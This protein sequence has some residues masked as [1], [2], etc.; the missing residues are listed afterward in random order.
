M[1]VAEVVGVK[2]VLKEGRNDLRI[3]FHSPVRRGMEKLKQL[4]YIIPAVNEQAP[5]GERSN[6]FTRKAPFHYGW[7]WGPR[8]VTSGVWRPVILRAVDAAVLEDV[9][10]HTRSAGEEVAELEGHAEVQVLE[11]GAYTLSLAYGEGQQVLKQELQLE[12]GVQQLPLNFDLQQPRLWWSKGLGEAYLYDFVFELHKE[13]KLVDRHH[14]PFGVRTLRLVQEPDSVGHS[15]YFELNGVPVFMKGANVIP[16][17]TLIPSVSKAD[18]ERLIDNAVAAN[19]NMV[20]VWGGAIY[21]EDYF[22]ELCDQKDILVWQD[23]MF[24]CRSEERRVG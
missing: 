20:R 12:A 2:Q 16:S 23:F 1:F 9:Y 11:A 8:L 4:D 15:F 10:L 18:Y 21:E 7:D 19:M 3:H 17:H 6:V 14:L 24:G 13:G 22:Y 5:E